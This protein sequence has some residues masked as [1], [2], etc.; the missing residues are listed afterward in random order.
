MSWVRARRVSRDSAKQSVLAVAIAPQRVDAEG[1]LIGPPKNASRAALAGADLEG[2][3]LRF[4]DLTRANLRGANL[5]NARLDGADLS[6]ADL[7]N[8]QLAGASFGTA[9]LVEAML[10]GADLTGVDFSVVTGLTPTAVRRAKS[11]TG[12]RW[13]PGFDPIERTVGGPLLHRAPGK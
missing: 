1:R 12:V 2:A 8:A 9:R 5:T 11:L 4:A 6:W 3:D 13:P 7:E 10:T